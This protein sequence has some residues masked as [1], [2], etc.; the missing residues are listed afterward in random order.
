M[1]DPDKATT[2]YANEIQK[3]KDTEHNFNGLF[4]KKY[5][6]NWILETSC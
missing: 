4:A 6:N 1:N 3:V 5:F 2:Y